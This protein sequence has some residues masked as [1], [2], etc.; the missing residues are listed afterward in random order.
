MS[1]AAL[2]EQLAA[3]LPRF[4]VPI[5]LAAADG[6]VSEVVRLEKALSGL[7]GVQP[8]KAEATALRG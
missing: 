4:A 7:Q 2:N 5:D 6:L 1:W 3:L 8:T